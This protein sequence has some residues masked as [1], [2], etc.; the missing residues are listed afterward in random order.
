MKSLTGAPFALPVPRPNQRAHRTME[1][2]RA[3]VAGCRNAPFLAK[4]E[5]TR[6]A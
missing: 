1:K 4:G 6:P 2:V 3:T 5:E